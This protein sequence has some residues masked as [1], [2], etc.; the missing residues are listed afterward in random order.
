MLPTQG[1]RTSA[2]EQFDKAQRGAKGRRAF[3]PSRLSAGL[4]D[5]H[6]D[7]VV[8]FNFV[9]MHASET[10]ITSWTLLN[11]YFDILVLDIYFVS[12]VVKEQPD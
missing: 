3:A 7:F 10:P 9:T 1:S 11:A 5:L 6:I 12:N 4:C 2:W 8:Q